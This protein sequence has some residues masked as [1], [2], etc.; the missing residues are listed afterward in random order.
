MAAPFDLRR[1]QKLTDDKRQKLRH[2]RGLVSQATLSNGLGDWLFEWSASRVKLGE[3]LYHP[4][5]EAGII[6]LSVPFVL[7]FSVEE[8]VETIY[9]EVGHALTP[10]HGHDEIWMAKVAALGCKEL[11]A[12]ASVSLP[13]RNPRRYVACC[14]Y[15]HRV[16]QRRKPPK[17][18]A[19][20]RCQGGCPADLAILDW[21]DTAATSLS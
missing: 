4:S 9:H 8:A 5:F 14:A 16:Y 7:A 1:M 6:S 17:A 20:Y 19:V 12:C 2:F 15:R 11:R 18:G 13:P 10:G 3:A 21:R